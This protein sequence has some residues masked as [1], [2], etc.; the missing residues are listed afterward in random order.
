VAKQYRL[1]IPAWALLWSTFGTTMAEAQNEE[2]T[3]YLQG[4]SLVYWQVDKLQNLDKLM[5]VKRE[6]PVIGDITERVATLSADVAK[7][8]EQLA[9]HD[10]N[11][12][13]DR[14]YLP[15]VEA[16][17]RDRMGANIA[18]E[19]LFSGGCD[20]EQRLVF[21]QT[22][23]VLRMSALAEEMAERAPNDEH[24]DFW[25]GMHERSAALFDEV[26]ELINRCPEE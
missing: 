3:D 17:A 5:L 26:R 7:E 24:A 23:A 8:L 20:F 21:T 6:R 19:L 4:F 13:L 9:E 11:I 10:Q 16:G 22:V 12:L 18:T 15:S 14:E 25:N 2:I 1:L